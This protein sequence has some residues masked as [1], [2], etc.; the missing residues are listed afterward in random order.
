MPRPLYFQEKSPSTPWRVGF[1]GSRDGLDSVFMGFKHAFS[2]LECHLELL[3]CLRE[4]YDMKCAE[5][6]ILYP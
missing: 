4:R 3:R 2:L 6:Y 1:V 5:D